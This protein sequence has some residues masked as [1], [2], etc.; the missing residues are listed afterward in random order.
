[1]SGSDF[2]L[3]VEQYHRALDAVVK[4]DP[5][6]MKELFS[7]RED[8]TLAN[9]LGP[10]VRGWSEVEKTMERAISNLR[11]GEPTRF[12]RISGDVGTELAYIVEVER[13]RAKLGGSDE[14]S[15]ISLRTTTIFRLEDGLWR[16]LHRHADPITSPRPI[17][18]I[19]QT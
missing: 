11:E 19:I 9:P 16:V 10:P 1:M 17:E 8:V 18:S 6:P 3:V 7:R 15:P 5:A 12:E 4:G 13:T 14:A 2:D